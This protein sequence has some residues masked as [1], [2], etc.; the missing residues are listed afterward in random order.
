ME[1]KA[2]FYHIVNV[3]LP[4]LVLI[5]VI[6]F[7]FF[8]DIRCLVD[9]VRGLESIGFELLITISV[10][11]IAYEVGYVVFR[12]GAVAIKPIL[13]ILFKEATYKDFI[14]AGKT[15]KRAFAK[16][17]MLSRE[18]AYARTHVALSLIILVFSIINTQWILVTICVVCIVLFLFTAHGHTKKIREAV[19]EYLAE[20][21]EQ[22]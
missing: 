8:D 19:E 6:A 20:T 15:S 22:S 14:A 2:S 17:N 21:G 13:K 16:L 5:G 10:L 3:F 12:F 18:H 7:L 1:I 9:A 4:G 11:A